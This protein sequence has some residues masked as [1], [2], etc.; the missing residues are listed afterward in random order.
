MLGCLILLSAL[1]L[2][3]VV[4][5]FPR[6]GASFL[7]IGPL[8]AEA[9]ITNLTTYLSPL[10]LRPVLLLFIE[11]KCRKSSSDFQWMPCQL[12]GYLSL[13]ILFRDL[14]CVSSFSVFP[15][16]W[17]ISVELNFMKVR[18]AL[19]NWRIFSGQ[20]VVTSLTSSHHNFHWMTSE[21]SSHLFCDLS[22]KM[23]KCLFFSQIIFYFH[24]HHF[25]IFLDA[26]FS[27]DTGE[28]E[29]YLIAM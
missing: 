10:V 28:N 5:V 14:C 17:W 12:R 29:I 21:F 4:S 6:N 7:Y 25:D 2:R 11:A 15:Q 27:L 22:G 16:L 13:F 3:F 18:Y 19:L 1:L 9:R 24:V 20:G 23:G 26:K 8:A